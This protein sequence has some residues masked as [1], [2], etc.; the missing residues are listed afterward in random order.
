M[1]KQMPN[2]LL[3]S[4]LV[5]LAVWQLSCDKTSEVPS[6][7]SVVTAVGIN[8]YSAPFF[9]ASEKGFWKAEGLDVTEKYFTSGRLGLD[10]LLAGSADIITVAETPIMFAGFS[11]Q[12]VVVV[13][14]I[15]SSHDLKV[16]ARRDHKINKPE[17]LRGKKVA[18]LF[19]ATSEYY[20]SLFLAAHGM[21]FSDIKRVNLN[22]PDMPVALVRGDIDAYV[23]WEPFI[24]NAYRELGE[25]KAVRFL[26]RDI[27]TL[28]FNMAVRRDFA[29]Q[30]PDVVQRAL[31]AVL[32][33]E[34]FISEHPEEAIA[35]TAK[36]VG[37]ETEVLKAIWGDYEF[38][39]DLSPQLVEAMKREAQW[40]TTAKLAPSEAAIP[41]YGQFVDSRPLRAVDPSRVT[42]K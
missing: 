4:L 42:I 20:A 8:A 9:I 12:N 25:E 36:K 29:E 34:K 5:W 22:P 35:I 38:K 33:A 32:Q 23:I 31:R 3:M 16:I 13:A 41:D 14:T 39:V 7:Q 15:L 26:K 11:G 24:Y 17:D 30:H 37:I 18:M 10:A 1:V 28:P 19:G 21:G 40:A 2:V 27:Y 6:K